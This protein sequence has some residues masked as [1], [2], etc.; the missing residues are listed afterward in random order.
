VFVDVGGRVGVV[1][2]CNETLH[3]SWHS[4]S[5]DDLNHRPISSNCTQLCGCV[6][7][8][9][10]RARMASFLCALCRLSHLPSAVIGLPSRQTCLR[11]NTVAEVPRHPGSLWASTCIHVDSTTAQAVERQCATCL[12]ADRQMIEPTTGPRR[13]CF[14]ASDRMHF[15]LLQPSPAQAVQRCDCEQRVTNESM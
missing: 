14:F 2:S 1:K 9:L 11:G 15:S 12:K 7:P 4:S 10:A 3:A 8:F 6:L 5:A 13:L